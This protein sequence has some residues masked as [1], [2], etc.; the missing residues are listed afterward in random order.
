MDYELLRSL[1]LKYI[2][3]L[4]SKSW[5][6]YNAHD[7]GITIMEQ[8]CYALTEL[9]YRSDFD[10][11]DLM[12][13]KDG[14]IA[15]LQ[16]FFSAKNILSS[17][18]LTVEDYRKLL[19]DIDGVR[20]AWLYPFRDGDFQLVGKPSQE[21]P[22]YAHC[23][24]DILTYQETEHFIELKGLYRVVLDLEEHD[25]FGDLNNGVLAFQF[26]AEELQGLKFQLLFPV[27]NETDHVFFQEADPGSLANNQLT[28]S[29]DRWKVSF[30]LSDGTSVK[31]LEME[32][33]LPGRRDL[34][35]ID[36]EELK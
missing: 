12:A 14:N 30:E 21:V 31:S 8:L 4:G 2:E 3:E 23:K 1:G 19:V 34:S 17:A 13:D 7:P 25:A 33:M 24:K 28:S 20:N 22:L 15:G 18:P 36:P 9:G 6:D 32:V 27:W 10:I 35:T 26:P 29:S 11:L 16:T 5:T